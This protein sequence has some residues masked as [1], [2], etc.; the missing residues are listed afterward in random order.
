MPSRDA[1][2]HVSRHHPPLTDS[3]RRLVLRQKEAV[4]YS[5]STEDFSLPTKGDK[6]RKT[7]PR[8]LSF[9]IPPRH[10][11][12]LSTARHNALLLRRLLE[13]SPVVVVPK[14]RAPPTV[15]CPEK[16][17]VSSQPTD[18]HEEESD[19]D[20]PKD[21]DLYGSPTLTPPPVPDDYDLYGSPTLTPPTQPTF[22]ASPAK[23]EE[24]ADDVSTAAEEDQI[25]FED[26]YVPMETLAT[27]PRW[28]S[29]LI[30]TPELY[31]KSPRRA[32][33]RPSVARHYP[34]LF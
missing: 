1:T 34:P 8:Q 22:S 19:F 10:G 27:D 31:S 5:R 14:V 6:T 13:T 26:S 3:F 32:K 15:V 23:D 7:P 29:S 20:R 17:S 24:L 25:L 16:S 33:R 11:S 12:P 30:S 21:Y 9:R 4:S 28:T 2:H 18:E